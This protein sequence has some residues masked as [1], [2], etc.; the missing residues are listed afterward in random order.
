MVFAWESRQV[1]TIVQILIHSFVTA[2]WQ[3]LSELIQAIQGSI[4]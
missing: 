4:L 3:S 1:L 2:G